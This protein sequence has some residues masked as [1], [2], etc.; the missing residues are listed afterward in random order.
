MF[1]KKEKETILPGPGTVV[2]ANVKLTGAIKD[3][4]E[5]IVHGQVEGEVS[6]A[7]TIM[8]GETAFIKGPVS[9]QS[10]T[11][12]GKIKGEVAA[13]NKLE[14]LPGSQLEGSITAR[15]LIIRSGAIFNGK[16]VIIADKKEGG[17]REE[18]KEETIKPE[19]KGGEGGKQDIDYEVEK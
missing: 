13:E 6:S 16:C 9:A 10:I 4:N 3:V 5:I 8:I 7:K 14:L 11:V 12:A 15:D 1:E 19:E 17:D 18:K 2:G